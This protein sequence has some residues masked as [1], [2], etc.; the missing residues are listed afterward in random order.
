MF[1]RNMNVRL[2][3]GAWE[4]KNGHITEKFTPAW[5][6]H[7]SCTPETSCRLAGSTA[8][9]GVS[10]LPSR[11]SASITLR[12]GL[13]N[14]ISFRI[15]LSLCKLAYSMTLNRMFQS[16]ANNNTVPPLA[17]TC[18]SGS[19]SREVHELSNKMAS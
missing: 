13:V 9:V 6:T 11:C 16:R 4:L 3:S 12:R 17:M 18:K 19:F 10:P 15:F 2:L 8:V 14:C 7:K 1:Y 5:I